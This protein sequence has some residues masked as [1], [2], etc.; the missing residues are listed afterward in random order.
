MQWTTSAAACSAAVTSMSR[1]P[2]TDVSEPA[3][4]EVA[5]RGG[6]LAKVDLAG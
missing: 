5:G 3:V 4:G 2:D 1:S 6:L